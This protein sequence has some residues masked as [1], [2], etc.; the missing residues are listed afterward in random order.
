MA[1]RKPRSK[2][3]PKAASVADH[4]HTPIPAL[5]PSCT[6]FSDLPPEI[7]GTICDLLPPQDLLQLC[8]LS[9]A[10][11]SESQRVIFRTVDLTGS[12]LTRKKQLATQVRSLSLELPR[13][14]YFSISADATRLATALGKCSNLTKLFV[15]QC[16]GYWANAIQTYLIT[17]A[18]FRLTQFRNGYFRYNMLSQFWK[19]QRDIRVLS[20][21]FLGDAPF[22]VDD[23]KL[24]NLIGLEVQ[25]TESL[26]QSRPLQANS[27][28]LSG[29]HPRTS[30]A[31][32][33]FS[34]TLTM[35]N[36]LNVDTDAPS[37]RVPLG[38]LTQLETFVLHT[39][40]VKEFRDYDGAGGPVTYSLH[41]QDAPIEAFATSLIGRSRSLLKVEVG[42]FDLAEC[43]KVLAPCEIADRKMM[44]E[45]TCTLERSTIPGKLVME[46]GRGFNFSRAAKFWDI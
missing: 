1:P 17:Q 20:L 25:C 15:Q 42:G 28:G 46:S 19:A 36:L 3:R 26:P 24:P 8:T 45:A 12:R 34:A 16:N 39:Y 22:P 27:A 6:T 10:F 40:K 21:L 38:N 37:P 7:C 30:S 23:E 18:R 2:A 4:P 14:E 41:W 35:L 44:F 9:R 32:Q 31:L 5:S 43:P 33:R 11:A 13:P 29:C